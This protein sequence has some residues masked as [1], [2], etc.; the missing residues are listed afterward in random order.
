[1]DSVKLVYQLLESQFCCKSC[2]DTFPVGSAGSAGRVGNSDNRA[3]SAQ[4][5][6]KLPT[7]AELG[8]IFG[9]EEKIDRKACEAELNKSKKRFVSES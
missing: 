7:G 4:F 5:Q 8:N 3:N 6:V 1:M 9:S 2:F